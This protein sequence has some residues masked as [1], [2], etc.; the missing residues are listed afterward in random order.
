MCGVFAG[1]VRQIPPNIGL[2][3]RSPRTIKPMGHVIDIYNFAGG[4]AKTTVT[5]NLG[6]HL[7]QLGKRVALPPAKL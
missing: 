4:S 5:L 2:C 6:Y 1:D 3:A 7:A